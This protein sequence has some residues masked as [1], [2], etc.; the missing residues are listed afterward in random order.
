MPRVPPVT[1]AVWPASE[2]MALDAAICV[3]VTWKISIDEWNTEVW[4]LR[5]VMV[6]VCTYVPIRIRSRTRKEPDQKASAGSE[7]RR[8]DCC[9]T[10]NWRT[11]E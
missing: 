4:G 1:S 10:A 5:L 6:Y 8:R 3:R 11:M 7:T 2:N 9:K